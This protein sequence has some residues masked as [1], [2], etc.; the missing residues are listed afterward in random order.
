[1]KTINLK[2]AISGIAKGK[3]VV[4][5][6]DTL[7]GLGADIYNV[8]SVK[9]IYQVK[10]RPLDLPL[11]V[12]VSDISMMKKIAYI[13]PP[14]KKIITKFLPGPL[15]IILKKK[16]LVPDSITQEKVA[17]RI[18]NN[19]IA[20]Q[21]ASYCGPLTATSANIHGGEDPCTIDIAKKQIGTRDIIYLD[22]GI[23]PCIPSTII[24]PTNNDIIIYREGAISKEDLYG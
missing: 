7:Y 6:T 17:I 5:P 24:E 23:L 10:R 13:T 18:P 12:M 1:M 16:Q 19:N 8:S 9:K 22:H 3:L 2:N 11:P 15:T 20:L 21:L 14:A 4:Y